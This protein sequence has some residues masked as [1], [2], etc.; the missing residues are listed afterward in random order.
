[1]KKHAFILALLSTVLFTACAKPD[2]VEETSVAEATSS[3]AVSDG[4]SAEHSL[5]IQML[6]SNGLLR[7]GLAV[8]KNEQSVTITI[9]QSMFGDLTTEE[10]ITE[11]VDFGATAVTIT[12]DG[13]IKAEFA[14]E[15][16]AVILEDSAVELEEK[17]SVT[18]ED[19]DMIKDITF[20]E[21]RNHFEVLCDGS[22]SINSTIFASLTFI[23]DIPTYQIF[24]GVKPEDVYVEI[25][26]LD[27]DTQELLAHLDSREPAAAN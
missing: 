14:P 24:N 15:D 23:A 20:N 16:Y 21:D 10:M 18:L 12:A 2:A 8:E 4:V 1:M 13:A 27:A 22:H 19:N 25:D 6:N 17:I 9:P 11:Q 7:S 5:F 3:D 26:Y